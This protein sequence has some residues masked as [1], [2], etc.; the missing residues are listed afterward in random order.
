M[1]EGK[2]AETYIRS[3]VSATAEHYYF[4]SK[5]KASSPVPI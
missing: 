4:Y 5:A 3:F 2:L 1:D